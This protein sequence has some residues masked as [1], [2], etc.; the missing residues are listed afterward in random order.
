MADEADRME[1]ALTCFSFLDSEKESYE[2]SIFFF[3]QAQWSISLD[4]D[5]SNIWCHVN[6]KFSNITQDIWLLFY[7]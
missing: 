5:Y 7:S 6:G 4:G 1:N 2:I 3:M